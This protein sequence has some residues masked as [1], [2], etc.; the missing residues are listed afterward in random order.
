M[1]TVSAVRPSTR[2]V[3]CSGCAIGWRPSGAPWSWRAIPAGVRARQ[4]PPLDL[5]RQ[6]KRS[7]ALTPLEQVGVAAIG[8]HHISER[9]ARRGH[10]GHDL[11]VGVV[12]QDQLEH[13][14]RVSAIGLRQDQLRAAVDT[15]NIHLLSVNVP[16]WSRNDLR[17]QILRR[18]S[19]CNSKRLGPFGSVQ[20]RRAL[21]ICPHPCQQTRPSSANMTH[22]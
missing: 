1:M 9:V 16:G 18:S 20:V 2:A 5:R 14:D 17:K 15:G 4:Q 7:R 6:R 22:R 21:H 13:A 19:W 12:R 8:H 3:G 10:I 11:R